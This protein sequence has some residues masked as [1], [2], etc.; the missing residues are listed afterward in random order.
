MH[1]FVSEAK[2]LEPTNCYYAIIS[3]TSQRCYC[4]YIIVI[5]TSQ[6]FY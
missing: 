6:C 3:G 4:Y 1:N 5:V 2:S